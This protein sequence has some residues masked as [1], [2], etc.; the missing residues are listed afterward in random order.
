M[1]LDQSKSLLQQ[2]STDNYEQ[3]EPPTASTSSADMQRE[4]KPNTPSCQTT[5]SEGDQTDSSLSPSR[6]FISAIQSPC[7]SLPPSQKSPTASVSEWQDAHSEIFCDSQTIDDVDGDLASKYP[8]DTF[9]LTQRRLSRG[10]SG[11]Q[12]SHHSRRVSDLADIEFPSLDLFYGPHLKI[13]TEEYGLY[14]MVY[15][16]TCNMCLYP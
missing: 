9:G 5:F 6:P 8:L 10:Q 13:Y 11:S 7:S 3:A 12:R 15:H 4:E 14:S 16:K 1:S 2:M